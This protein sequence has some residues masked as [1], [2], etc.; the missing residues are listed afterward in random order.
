[1][2]KRSVRCSSCL[3]HSSHVLGFKWN[4]AV[5]IE[6]DRRDRKQER[7]GRKG[8]RKEEKG[9]EEEKRWREKGGGEWIWDN[10]EMEMSMT[11]AVSQNQAG[12]KCYKKSPPLH[13]PIPLFCKQRWAWHVPPD[14]PSGS[15]NGLYGAKSP[16]KGYTRING[17][18]VNCSRLR[19]FFFFLLFSLLLCHLEPCWLQWRSAEGARRLDANNRHRWNRERL[20]WQKCSLHFVPSFFIWTMGRDGVREA[21]NYWYLLPAIREGETERNRGRSSTPTLLI[22]NSLSAPCSLNKRQSHSHTEHTHEHKAKTVFTFSF[23]SS[24]FNKTIT[25]GHMIAFYYIWFCIV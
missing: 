18:S 23:L 7:E 5:F 21:D 15:E 24:H 25:F 1:M 13:P 12:W 17:R 19:S 20:Y 6:T 2:W 16:G 14:C 11:K 3:A 4:A 22:K 10:R 8:R 9:G